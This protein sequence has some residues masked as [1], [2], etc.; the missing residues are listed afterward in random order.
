MNRHMNR[1]FSLH[2]GWGCSETVFSSL[3]EE[4]SSELPWNVLRKRMQTMFSGTIFSRFRVR[5]FFSLLDFYYHQSPDMEGK[6]KWFRRE[7]FL[8]IE[9]MVRVQEGMG[10][11]LICVKEIFFFYEN[12]EFMFSKLSKLTMLHSY[13][14]SF[15]WVNSMFGIVWDW[16]NKFIHNK[17]WHCNPLQPLTSPCQSRLTWLGLEHWQCLLPRDYVT[18]VA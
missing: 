5:F 17:H 8:Y 7:F 18:L 14:M 13:P 6:L 11:S 1:K 15:L 16:N 2:S 3:L 10:I 9:L 12:E 4:G